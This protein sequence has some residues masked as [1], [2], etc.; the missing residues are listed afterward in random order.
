MF[1]YSSLFSGSS[2]KPPSGSPT[3][4]VD[5]DFDSNN[6]YNHSVPGIGFQSAVE[7]DLITGILNLETFES[8]SLKKIAKELLGHTSQM[9]A[10]VDQ[11][12]LTESLLELMK[13]TVEDAKQSVQSEQGIY[14]NLV[15]EIL[16][17]EV[18]S[19]AES[20][21]AEAGDD[22]VKDEVEK[23]YGV[24]SS[25]LTIV[26]L[27]GRNMCDKAICD[28]YNDLDQLKFALDERVSN[29]ED[30]P[31][32]YQFKE[33]VYQVL[34]PSIHKLISLLDSDRFDA[35]LRKRLVDRACLDF[36]VTIDEANKEN[37]DL[38]IRM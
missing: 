16:S 29:M 3:S 26:S 30:G 7:Y 21:L 13:E 20:A 32:K 35:P 9:D 33:R 23:L 12:I 2:K 11:R 19:V 15:N 27:F 37:G 10:R 17:G 34:L 28:K 31:V 38:Q 25:R 24:Y 14:E 6:P 36:Q 22:T 5:T 8:E 1:G 4:V 18:K